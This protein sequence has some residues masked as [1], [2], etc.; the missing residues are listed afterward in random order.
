[1]RP[2]SCT[3]E[4]TSHKG[5]EDARVRPLLLLGRN[6]TTSPGATWCTR[7]YDFPLRNPPLCV[8]AGC[9][10]QNSGE[11]ERVRE[12]VGEKLLYS[13][14]TPSSKG[15]SAGFISGGGGTRMG[16]VVTP[17]TQQRIRTFTSPG[18]WPLIAALRLSTCMWCVC[19]TVSCYTVRYVTSR[20]EG[21]SCQS[22]SGGTCI[23]AAHATGG[24]SSHERSV[25]S[26]NKSSRTRGASS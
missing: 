24:S 3:C 13:R 10:A 14:P 5:R 16:R 2:L 25:R 11:R 18:P 17:L 23:W 9:S 22:S 6:S 8:L 20:S 7:M 19:V 26:A 21:G 12:S 4:A 15:P 1:M